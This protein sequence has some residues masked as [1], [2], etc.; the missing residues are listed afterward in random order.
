MPTA[1]I[2]TGTPAG[3]QNIY[4]FPIH[5]GIGTVYKELFDFEQ[6]LSY[7][8]TAERYYETSPLG[9]QFFY[10]ISIGNCYYEKGDYEAA[11]P[12]FRRARNLLD[13][14]DAP[15]YA[16]L[17][18]A[19]LGEI[20][21][22]LHRTDSASPYIDRSYEFYRRMNH[23]SYF[24]HI[25]TVKANL[26]IEQKNYSLAASI[27]ESCS[28]TTD[29]EPNYLYYRKRS[30][31]NYYAATGRYDKAYQYQAA[32]K[33]FSDSLR[34]DRTQKRVAEIDLRYKQDT[35]LLKQNLIITEKSAQVQKLQHRFYFI[36]LILLFLVFT[37]ITIYMYL[38]RQ[39][40]I[41]FKRHIAQVTKL[42]ME[43]IRNRVSPHFIFNVLNRR[44]AEENMNRTDGEALRELV[45]M[46]RRSLEV[47]EKLTVLLPEEI[48][49]VKNYISLQQDMFQDTLTV[50]WNID[51]K[52][53]FSDFEIPAMIIQIP[54]ENAI[55]HGLSPLK[56]DK[57]LTIT[58]TCFSEGVSITIAD[59]GT[60]F[61]PSADS[62]TRGTGTGLKVL[63]Q[64]IEI[65]NSRNERRITFRIENNSERNEPGTTV[66]IF[67][68]QSFNYLL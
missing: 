55:K 24:Y 3:K 62:S 4:N 19:N 29:I 58:V 14:I 59:N 44:I 23:P 40:D 41:Q 54:V 31:Q 20:F 7:F 68:P 57:K 65:L 2:T 56:G 9:E 52:P 33:A 34:H 13:N 43:S 61:K 18:E 66:R 50:H 36:L 16:N 8:K 60:G 46:L 17:A 27:F 15:F 11:L 48:E 39:R 38:R 37:G 6:A 1:R 53:G 63:F 47:T 49:F 42:R 67:I 45:F 21:L 51:E 12:W 26:A 5:T 28:D 32:V 64:T 30:L 22:L 25:S 10:C 35:T